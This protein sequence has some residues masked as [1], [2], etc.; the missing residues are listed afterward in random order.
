M[1]ALP[2]LSFLIRCSRGQAA[3]QRPQLKHPAPSISKVSRFL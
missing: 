3:K 1:M 2:F